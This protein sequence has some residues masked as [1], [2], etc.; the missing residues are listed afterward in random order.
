MFS[1]Q[2]GYFNHSPCDWTSPS[3]INIF[4]LCPRC[5]PPGTSTLSI[6]TRTH[7]RTR[8]RTRTH[9]HTH[10][11]TGGHLACN[12]D[13]LSEALKVDLYE[14]TQFV[15]GIGMRVRI[16]SAGHFREE[17]MN[18]QKGAELC[19]G[20]KWLSGEEGENPLGMSQVSSPPPSLTLWFSHIKGLFFLQT[21]GSWKST[22]YMTVGQTWRE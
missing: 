3:E 2:N 16:T 14:V 12:F 6:L 9:T 20:G 11:I 21:W 19:G 8:T 15:G 17:G 18:V 7:A 13:T 1:T 5:I 10:T 22:V 4:L